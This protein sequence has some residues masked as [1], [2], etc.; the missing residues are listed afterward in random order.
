MKTSIAA[1]L[2]II[3]LQAVAGQISNPIR[4]Y[5]QMDVP[6]RREFL[7]RYSVLYRAK[8]DIDGDGKDE[9]LVGA[10]YEQSGSKTIYWSLYAPAESQYVRLS[11]ATSDIAISL[12]NAFVGFV[13]EKAKQGLL[14]TEEP[15]KNSDREVTFWQK[16]NFFYIQDGVLRQE[17]LAPLDLHVAADEVF[18]EKYFGEHRKSRPV[19]IEDFTVDELREQGLTVPTWT[20][21]P[22]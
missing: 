22:Q 16:V 18:C 1:V 5:L 2:Y 13:D 9:V 21:V 10:R 20:P 12:G 11:P 17:Q 15:V 4:D 19:T 14:V 3:T 8:C 7:D 6:E